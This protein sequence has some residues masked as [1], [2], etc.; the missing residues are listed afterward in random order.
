MPHSTERATEIRVHGAQYIAH[1]AVSRVY[2][3]RIGEDYSY[4]ADV[5]MKFLF[6]RLQVDLVFLWVTGA[7]VAQRS[8]FSA[9]D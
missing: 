3:H 1:T 8:Q 9:A 7:S 4:V 2:A 5:F 6:R